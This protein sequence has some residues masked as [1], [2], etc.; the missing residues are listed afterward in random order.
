MAPKTI[1]YSN[2]II[3]KIQHEDND[4]LLYVG[5][6]TDF[7]RRKSFHKYCCNNPNGKAYNLKVYKM[8]RDNGG[9][10]SFKM[11]EIKK[12]ACN[13]SREACAEEERI[14]K[15]LSPIMNSYRAY[16]E[17]T[18]QER[19]KQWRNDNPNYDKQYNI[20]NPEQ[21]KIRQKRW[22][23]KNKITCDCGSVINKDNLLRHLDTGKHFRYVQNNIQ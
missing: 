21:K 10:E 11:I 2:T 12:F 22:R 9:W 1:N 16:S 20:D 14:R 3:Y 7:I 18:K 13:D 4:D 19:N 8:I 5:S 15:Q 6:T 23:E 17:L